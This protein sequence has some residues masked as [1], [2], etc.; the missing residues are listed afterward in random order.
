MCNI[1]TTFINQKYVELYSLSSK[2]TYEKIFVDAIFE[3][4][5]TFV[6]LD[7]MFR[8]NKKKLNL[9]TTFF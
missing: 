1:F 7:L 2:M 5:T 3:G 9:L 4:L 8:F 6:F